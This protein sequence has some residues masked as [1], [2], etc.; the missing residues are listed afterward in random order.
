M[1]FTTD[2]LRFIL[3]ACDSSSILKVDYMTRHDAVK[4]HESF[5]EKIAKE[6][7]KRYTYNDELETEL[8]ET[9]ES[10][11]IKFDH[12]LSGS[13]G[14]KLDFYLPAYD[15]YIEVKKFYSD[16][17]E[18]QLQSQENVILLQGRK[19]V[20]FFCNLLSDVRQVGK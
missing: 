20:K 16:R 6:L 4:M 18:V 1:T 19:A 8:A 9:L 14:R 17:S 2:E 10:T 5:R 7:Q 12:E 3:L 13:T 15:V 11:G